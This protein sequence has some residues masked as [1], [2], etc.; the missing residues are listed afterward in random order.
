M[1]FK[2]EFPG[3]A[4]NK[5][6]WTNTIIKLG[7]VGNKKIEFYTKETIRGNC[8][9]KQRA[10]EIIEK[11]FKKEYIEGINDTACI[12]IKKKLGLK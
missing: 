12:A 11:Y 10:K 2:K 8:L 6:E 5:P 3:L 9:D 4:K 1:N 7:S